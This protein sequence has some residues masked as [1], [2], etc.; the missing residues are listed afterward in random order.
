MKMTKPL[1]VLLSLAVVLHV[2]VAQPV[3]VVQD[4]APLQDALLQDE[5][6][7]QDALLQE[8]QELVLADAELQDQL[9]ALDAERDMIVT[10]PIPKWLCDVLKPVIPLKIT[11][12]DAI[13]AQ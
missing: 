9:G 1:L 3:D 7:L 12:T 11:C 13:T 5:A 6:P 4:E 10:V 2:A 8:L